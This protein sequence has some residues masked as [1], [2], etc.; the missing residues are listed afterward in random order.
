MALTA[1]APGVTTVAPSACKERDV[2]IRHLTDDDLLPAAT[3]FVA[4]LGGKPPVDV[5]RFR[6]YWDVPASLG[7]FDTDGMLLGVAA[8]FASR[9]TAVGG[10]P[11]SCYTVPSVGVR[12]D[13]Q[14]MGIGRAL[15]EQQV[16]DAVAAGAAVM[17][18][19]ASES[20]IYGRYGYGPTSAWQTIELGLRGLQFRAGAP[21]AMPGSITELAIE[22]AA[23][24]LPALHARCFGRWGGELERPAGVWWAQLRPR[25]GTS[26]PTTYAGLRDGSGALVAAVA[27]TVEQAFDDIA[28]ANVLEVV[29]LFGIDDRSEAV[30][31]RWLCERALAGTVKAERWNPRSVLGMLLADGRMLRTT[32]AADAVWLRVLDVPAV[33]AARPTMGVGTVCVRVTDAMVASNDRTWAIEGIDGQLRC[34]P[35]EAGPDVTVPIEQLAPLLW[36]FRRASA[37]A[38]AALIE[39]HDQAALA[40]LDRLLATDSPSW[41]SVGF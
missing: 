6:Q 23:Q 5:E 28:F 33:M 19:N 39:V 30:L 11:L 41:C 17:A 10:A 14:G 21:R 32:M 31:A 15:L 9:F 27:F 13:R 8:T 20:G 25:P 22:E 4:S 1:R 16:V 29:D 18:L 35:S 3:T 7:A 37:L 2:Q 40:T 38:S 34:T 26:L 36:G 12:P 24:Q